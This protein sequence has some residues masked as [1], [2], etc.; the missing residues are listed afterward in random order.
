MKHIKAAEKIKRIL[1]DIYDNGDKARS[2]KKHNLSL[3]DIRTIENVYDQNRN[4]RSAYVLSEKIKS[5]FS[6]CGYTVTENG[7]GW[8]ISLQ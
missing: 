7:I 6:D 3:S 8:N 2:V 5:I 1:W 4:G